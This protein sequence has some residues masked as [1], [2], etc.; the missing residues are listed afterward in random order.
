MVDSLQDRQQTPTFWVIPWVVYMSMY[1]SFNTTAVEGALVYNL[2][3]PMEFCPLRMYPTLQ[4][5][6][7]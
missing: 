6:G 1:F 4:S 2:T 7:I 5:C 3:F